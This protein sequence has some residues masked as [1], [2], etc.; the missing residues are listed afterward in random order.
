MRRRRARG[1]GVASLAWA[2]LAL[3]PT[4]SVV[5][6][7]M[8]AFPGAHG[9]GALSLGGRRGR[10][11]HVTNLNDSGPGSLREAIEAR[12]PRTIVFDV[13]GTI[14]L[15]T[16]LVIRSGRVTVAGQTAPGGGITLRGSAA[17]ATS[18]EFHWP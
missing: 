14:R 9:A 17:I 6:A 12:E 8:V 10:V 16:P 2:G 11:F 13:G 5:A 18:P 4:A 7:Q 1:C 3:V 15:R